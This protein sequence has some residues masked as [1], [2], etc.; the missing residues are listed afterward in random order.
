MSK[1]VIHTLFLKIRNT[2][3]V[4]HYFK[5]QNDQLIAVFIY[6]NVTSQDTINH[7]FREGTE[8]LKQKNCVLTFAVVRTDN[9][10]QF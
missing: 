9:T 5:T 2:L 7:F 10:S 8:I 3:L 6:P 1:L 4:T